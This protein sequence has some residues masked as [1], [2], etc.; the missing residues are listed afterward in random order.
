MLRK[1]FQQEIKQEKEDLANEKSR[2]LS[3]IKEQFEE[4]IAKEKNKL[5]KEHREKM[6]VILKTIKEEEEEAEAQ[7]HEK[8][9]D[10]LRDLKRKVQYMTCNPIKGD[11]LTAC[12]FS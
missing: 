11:I 9:E 10:T 1:Q 8:K 12:T 7:L 4:E 3:L 6:D 2:K 5:E